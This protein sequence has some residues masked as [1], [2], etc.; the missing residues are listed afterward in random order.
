MAM[1]D[2]AWQTTDGAWKKGIEAIYAQLQTILKQYN[3][4]T[5]EPIGEPF[6]HHRHE[7]VG[8]EPTT[9]PEQQDTVMTVLQSGYELT[10]GETKHLIRPAR[11]TTGVLQTDN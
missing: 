6:D 5:I 3:V 7:A 10:E 9:N 1:Q 4:T 11:V 2:T 8:M